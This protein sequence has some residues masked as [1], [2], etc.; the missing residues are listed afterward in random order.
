MNESKYT[1][2]R[3]TYNFTIHFSIIRAIEAAIYTTNTDN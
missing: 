2:L 3:F 1:L